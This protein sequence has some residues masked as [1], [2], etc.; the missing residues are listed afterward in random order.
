MNIYK[1]LELTS[2]SRLLSLV[3]FNIFLIYG[4]KH[5]WSTLYSFFAL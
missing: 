5:I 2:V 3:E 4:T 1:S